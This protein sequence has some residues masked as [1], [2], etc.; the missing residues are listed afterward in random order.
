MALEEITWRWGQLSTKE[1]REG[2][3]GVGEGQKRGGI[4]LSHRLGWRGRQKYTPHLD[5]MGTDY[6]KPH[7][8]FKEEGGTSYFLSAG[9]CMISTNV[10]GCWHVCRKHAIH[11]KLPPSSS[12]PGHPGNAQRAG[13]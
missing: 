12:H 4:W 9:L 13:Y 5:I 1:R 6:E 7:R 2:G 8:K 11:S 3:G 10:S